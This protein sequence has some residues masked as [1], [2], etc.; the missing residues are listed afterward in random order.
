MCAVTH[1]GPGVLLLGSSEVKPEA[2]VINDRC[3]LLNQSSASSQEREEKKAQ[4]MYVRVVHKELLQI[5]VS[6]MNKCCSLVFA[7]DYL[8]I[9]KEHL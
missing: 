4:E 5:A 2:T 1:K 3:R 8:S 9:K 7:I 6:E